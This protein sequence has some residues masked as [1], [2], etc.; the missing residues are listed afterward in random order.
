MIITSINRPNLIVCNILH[1]RIMKLLTHICFS[2]VKYFPVFR[3]NSL[4]QMAVFFFFFFFFFLYFLSFPKLLNVFFFLLL[5]PGIKMY[6]YKRNRKSR[7]ASSW[8]SF[9]EVKK[10]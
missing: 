5:F 4:C 6:A 3:V 7:V 1:F 2:H 9:E 10:N 8:C